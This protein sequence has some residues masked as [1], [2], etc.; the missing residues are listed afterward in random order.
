MRVARLEASGAG[1]R[2]RHRIL[3]GTNERQ[4]LLLLGIGT[5]ECQVERLDCD[6]GSWM[7]CGRCKAGESEYTALGLLPD[8]RYRFR[9]SAVNRM[10]ESEPAEA[11]ETLTV[12]KEEDS[13]SLVRAT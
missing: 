5:A 6:K 3:P 9:V 10:G 12:D 7:A 13:D 1:R 8:R 4:S 11:Q 2:M